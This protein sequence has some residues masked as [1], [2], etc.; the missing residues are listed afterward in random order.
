MQHFYLVG[1]P[2][3]HGWHTLLFPT[4]QF[5]ATAMLISALTRSPSR[6]QKPKSCPKKLRNMESSLTIAVEALL[7]AGVTEETIGAHWH[8]RIKHAAADNTT[9]AEPRKVS[10]QPLQYGWHPWHHL[11]P[12]TCLILL[13][14]CA[15]SDLAIWSK[16]HCC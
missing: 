7:L 16:C 4:A 13:G 10:S 9:S 2:L 11:V 12:I 3:A 14:F 15:G 6:Q 1:T 5:Q 8:H